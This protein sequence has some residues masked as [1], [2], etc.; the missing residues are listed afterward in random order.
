MQKV[1]LKIKEV[2]SIFLKKYNLF[3]EYNRILVAFSGGSDSLCLLDVLYKLDL[4]P[5]AAHLNHNWRGDES[6]NE[7]KSAQTYCKERNIEFYTET[8]PPGLPQT[9]E[10]ARNQRYLFLNKTAEKTGATAILTGH[11]RTDN[12]ETVLYRIIKGTGI[13]GLKGI[14]EKREQQSHPAIYRPILRVTREECIKYCEE[15]ALSPS[16]DSSNYNQ[17][18]SRNR[19]RISLLPELQ[20]YNPEVGAA[21]LRLSEIAAD[22]DEII[23]EYIE[24]TDVLDDVIHTQS[25]LK[26]S[27]AL[28]KRIL[29]DFLTKNNVE[30]TFEN[31]NDLFGFIQEN[32]KSKTGKTFSIGKDLWVFVSI[33][34]VKLITKQAP[35]VMPVL[36][37]EDWLGDTPQTYPKETDNY[38]FVD[39]GGVQGP[40]YVRTRQ[41]GDRIQPFGMKEKTKLKKYLINRGIPQYT[42]D[43]IPLMAN[44]EEILWVLGVGISEKLRVKDVPTHIITLE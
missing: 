9:E 25:L 32:K 28:Q 34:E 1:S 26:Q 12:I 43:N 19:I 2:V 17:K 31:I 29:A 38:I 41:P 3:N 44:D 6:S 33:K 15:N 40:F 7:Q 13:T 37:I 36:K 18:Y 8:L 42:R 14:P 11:T 22:S 5:I 35:S 30:H 10:E 16:I 20:T 23:S 27:T 24:K 21:L 39:L 4:N